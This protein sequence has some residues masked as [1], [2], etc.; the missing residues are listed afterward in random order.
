[1]YAMTVTQRLPR[2]DATLLARQ[3]NDEVG[4][5]CLGMFPF[6]LLK[7]TNIFIVVVTQSRNWKFFELLDAY[8]STFRRIYFCHGDFNSLPLT[9]LTFSQLINSNV[10]W[11][12]G[13]NRSGREQISPVWVEYKGPRH[14]MSWATCIFIIFFL[15]TLMFITLG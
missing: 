3:S 9:F 5:V 13:K 14:D 7:L 12:P 15:T 10:V 1:M 2:R 6:L 11:V 4:V 8:I